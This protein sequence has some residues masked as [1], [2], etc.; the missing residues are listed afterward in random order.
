MW[1]LIA[2]VLTCALPLHAAEWYISYEKGVE[3]VKRQQWDTAVRELNDAI[4]GKSES[5]AD[6]KTYGLQFIDY[7]PYAYRG[8]AYFQLKDFDKAEADF[9]R[10]EQFGEVSRGER[11]RTARKLLQDT[12]ELIR[13]EKLAA[14]RFAEGKKLYD[15]K[16]YARAVD[17]FQAVLSVKPDHAEASRYLSL[18]QAELNKPKQEEPVAQ[19]EK[20]EETKTEPAKTEQKSTAQSRIPGLLT[21]GEKLYKQ[22][23]LNAAEKKFAAILD[24]DGNNTQAKNYVSKIRSERSALA[25]IDADYKEGV[26]LFNAG[27]LQAAETK[28]RSVLKAQNSHAEAQAYLKR[29]DGI[30]TDI[31]SG[32]GLGE[33]AFNEKNYDTAEEQFLAVLSLDKDNDQAKGFLSRIR[34]LR[35]SLSSQAKIDEAFSAGETLFNQGKVGEAKRKF[36]YCQSAGMNNEK[37]GQYLNSIAG[38]EKQSRE[39]MVAFLEGDYEKCIARLTDASKRYTDN[40]NIYAFLAGAYAAQFYI[41]GEVDKDLSAQA[42]NEYLKAKQ[43]KK[44]FSFDNAYVSPKIIQLLT[45]KN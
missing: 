35:G 42:R 17:E 21:D 32:L 10:E 11:D 2:L 27:N 28:F 7:F 22:G 14:T 25:R 31:Q 38:L 30:R 18:A 39:G 20:K 45:V 13:T 8:Y 29:I 41:H 19:A 44:D 16:S 36:L 12:K 9:A 43:L 5:S 26:R 24:I 34:T 1:L 40:P 23:D 33:R 15:Q 37:L 4:S 3:A 6:A